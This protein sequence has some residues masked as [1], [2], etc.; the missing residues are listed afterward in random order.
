M[1]NAAIY[2]GVTTKDILNN[3]FNGLQ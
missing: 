2:R 1:V 3:R